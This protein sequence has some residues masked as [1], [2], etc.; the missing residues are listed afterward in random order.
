MDE[1]GSEYNSSVTS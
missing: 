1:D